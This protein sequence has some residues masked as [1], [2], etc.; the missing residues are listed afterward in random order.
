MIV[1]VTGGRSYAG[2]GLVEA[3]D[4]LAQ[5]HQRFSI[6]VG[7]ATG[8]DRIAQA[9]ARDR[10]PGLLCVFGAAWASYGKAAG[11]QRNARMVSRAI[12]EHLR[13]ERVICLAAPGGRGT[14]DCVRRCREAGFEVRKVTT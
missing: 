10:K 11:P 3:L 9:W 1:I 4:A 14:A 7:D 5:E 13:G 8:A 6:F 12:A 2:T